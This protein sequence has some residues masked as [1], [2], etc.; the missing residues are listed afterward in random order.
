MTHDAALKK[1]NIFVL[2]GPSGS[3]KTSVVARLKAL[4]G[5]FYSVSATTRTPRTGETDGVDYLF[6]SKEVFESMIADSLLAEYAEVAGNLYGTP[7]APLDEALRS[8]GTAIVDID[9][10]GA[11]RIKEKFPEAILVFIAPP[12]TQVLE[13]RLRGRATDSDEAI[14]RRLQLARSEMEFM[15]RYDH[16]VVNDDL[17]QTVKTVENIILSA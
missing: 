14:T 15:P 4:P 10:Q 16:V 17:D 6:L 12:S 8:G 1:G 2:S 3:G 11:M 7:A 13:R 5:F 9:V